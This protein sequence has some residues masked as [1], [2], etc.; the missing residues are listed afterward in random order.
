MTLWISAT[1]ASHFLASRSF[2]ISS[3]RPATARDSPGST[4]SD[5]SW[6]RS[7]AVWQRKKTVNRTARR[8][9][10]LVG[11]GRARSV[12]WQCTSERM[13]GYRTGELWHD[14]GIL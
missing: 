7:T 11:A 14:L 12:Y 5:R 1:A 2:R 3:I 4:T 6:A 10:D 9:G 8:I 13:I